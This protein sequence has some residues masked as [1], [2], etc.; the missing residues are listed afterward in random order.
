MLIVKY[1][2]IYRLTCEHAASKL[3]SLVESTS[4]LSIITCPD[5][6]N[7]H[8]SMIIESWRTAARQLVLSGQCSSKESI[9]AFDYSRM[10]IAS[11]SNT[12][13]LLS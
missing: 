3:H 11:V 8:D 13:E 10:P 4:D 1:M 6:T 9:Q 5:N 2:C 12:V 7:C